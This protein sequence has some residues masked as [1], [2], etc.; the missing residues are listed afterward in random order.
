MFGIVAEIAMNLSIGPPSPLP[1]ADWV[2]ASED[3][4]VF[5]LLTIASTVGPRVSSLS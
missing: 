1:P 5:I 4:M 3:L 2:A